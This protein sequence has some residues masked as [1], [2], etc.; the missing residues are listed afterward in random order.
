MSKTRAIEPYEQEWRREVTFNFGKGG[1]DRPKNMSD[2]GID[3]EVTIMVTGKVK[4]VNASR[5]TSSFSLQMSKVE[6]QT[7]TKSNSLAADFKEA[8][9]KV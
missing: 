2:L 5:E 8:K 3:D 4:S 7:D 9:K 1:M 6:I